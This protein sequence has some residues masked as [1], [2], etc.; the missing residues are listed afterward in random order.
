M[1]PLGTDCGVQI[2]PPSVVARM[3]AP[4]PGVAE[5]TAVQLIM[6]AQ[7]MP[8]KLATTPDG[9]ASVLHV[10]P[11]LLVRMMLGAPEVE[12]KA[13]TAWQ[14]RV[15]EHETPTSLPTFGGTVCTV[16]LLPPSFVPMTVGVEKLENPT[17]IQLT[18]DPQEILSNPLT[19]AGMSCDAHS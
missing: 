18:T 10:T 7:P 5:P 17:A 16:Q 13:L 2:W 1:Y 9:S 4:G 14:L 15:V 11:P 12:S 19:L 6:S 3:E 8:V